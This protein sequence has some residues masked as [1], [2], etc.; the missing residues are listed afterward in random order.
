MAIPGVRV[1]VTERAG[2]DARSSGGNPPVG[3]AAGEVAGGRVDG[4]LAGTGLAQRSAVPGSGAAGDGAAGIAGPLTYRRGALVGVP[5]GL[6]RGRRL[7][8]RV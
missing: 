1:T 7:D 4:A 5:Q 6:E 2:R 8:V 3:E